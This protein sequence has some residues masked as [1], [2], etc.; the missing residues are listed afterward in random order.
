[1]YYYNTLLVIVVNALLVWHNYVC[2]I[3][4]ICY[5]N[6]QLYLA[7]YVI[8]ISSVI[9][10]V[11]VTV[12]CKD[13]LQYFRGADFYCFLTIHKSFPAICF[14]VNGGFYSTTCVCYL[15]KQFF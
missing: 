8:M 9:T 5:S 14:C 15:L 10:A 3:V 1:M 12:I 4:E 7:S 2:W 13:M 6:S 11:V